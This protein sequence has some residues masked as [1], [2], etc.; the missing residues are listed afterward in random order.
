MRSRLL[1]RI[2]IAAVLAVF[3]FVGVT[4][5]TLISNYQSLGNLVKVVS[6][7]RTQYLHE[8][9]SDK[10]M[11]GAIQGMVESLDDPYS[12][13][14]D[15]ET[16]KQLNQQIH[17]SFGGLGILVGVEDE[18]LTVVRPYEGTPAYEAGM[19]A[20]DKITEID[21]EDAKGIGLDT[22]INLMRGPIGTEIS[23]TVLRGDEQK[24]FTLVREEIRVPT[25]E[26]KVME[27]TEIGYI[28]LTQFNDNTPNEMT[29]TLNKLLKKDIEGLV[30]DLR[31]NPGGELRSVAKVAD[32]FITKGPV[33][34]IDY[35]SGDDAT[36]NAE[37]PGLD[38]PLVVLQNQH[39][40]SAAEIL[41]GAIKDHNLGTLVGTT[42][43]GKGVVQT[44]FPL[45]NGAG[46]KLT[47]A[48]YLTPDKHDINKKGI[49]PDVKIDL[50]LDATEDLQLEKAVEIMKE[51]LAS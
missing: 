48:R 17:G 5:Y 10:M 44:V 49:E 8:V 21:D 18:Y 12:T 50:P 14:L 3:L 15:A 31:N 7:I 38:L 46:L 16:F 11:E 42:S 22:A 23:L 20:G 30:L 19:K 37:K 40:A 32:Q 43:F 39:T 24:E 33:V 47:T 4:G 27:G 9:D 1:K 45:D 41:A 36:Y 13:Y 2:L 35:K 29:E 6:I 25:V 34:H 28:V 26:G 51:K